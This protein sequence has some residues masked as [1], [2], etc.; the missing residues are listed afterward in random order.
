MTV[1]ITTSRIQ[2]DGD[3]VET[4]FIYPFKIYEDDDLNAIVADSSGVEN[5]LILNTDYTVSGAGNDAGG[6]I[7]LTSGSLVPSGSTLTLIREFDLTQE[8]DHVDGQKTSAV[9]LEAPPDKSRLIDQQ[10][11][12]ILSRSLHLRVSETGSEAATTLPSLSDRIASQFLGFDAEGNFIGVA[13]VIPSSVIVSAFMETLLDDADAVT[14]RA[15]L[16]AA[17]ETEVLKKDGSVVMTGLL[18]LSGDP[19]SAL[20]AITKQYA[21]LARKNVIINGD[22]DIWQRGTN[23]TSNDYGSDDRWA[24]I[25]VGS[26][27]THT[28]QK[29]TLGQTDVPGNPKYYSRTVVS[30]SAGASNFVYKS[31]RIE[32]VIKYAGETITLSF[33]AK[34]DAS[35][36]IA[37]DFLQDFGTGGSPSSEITGIGV[38]THA[39]TTSWQKFTVSVAI[40][41][42][43]GKTLGNNGDDSSGLR[44]WFD[45]GSDFDAET[46]SLGQ[47][48]GT[49]EISRVQVEKGDVATNFE[50]RSIGQ[51]FAL[52]QRYYYEDDGLRLLAISARTT[53]QALANSVITLPTAMR[54]TPTVVLGSGGNVSGLSATPRSARTITVIGTPT[55]AAATASFAGY[56][57]DAEL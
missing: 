45:A 13:G 6:S 51:E 16:G 48:S 9:S 31:Q 7:T 11:L 34:A 21:D 30:S 55:S 19:T 42:V 52:C 47:Q 22:F 41:S 17:A 29:F 18:T 46:D 4:G 49:F 24:N 56:A 39:L 25:H 44:F 14:A 36:N 40:P 23:Q 38:A 26:T 53:F 43:S 28:Q 12:E 1:S 50:N 3:N 57:A 15:T 2:Y 8:T 33:Y 20:H 27:K 10:I 5:T 54:T 35:K 37:T 32:D